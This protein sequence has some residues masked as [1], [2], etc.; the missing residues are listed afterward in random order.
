MN[1][2][3]LALQVKDGD[4][5]IKV[6]AAPGSSRERV[7]GLHGDSLKVAVAAPPEKGK[8]NQAILR[9]LA[10]ALGWKPSRLRLESGETSRD[11]WVRIEEATPELVRER[12]AALL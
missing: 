12:L 11:K 5:L 4:V 3:R 9:V 7:C 2:P 8:A 6:R 10:A 1:E